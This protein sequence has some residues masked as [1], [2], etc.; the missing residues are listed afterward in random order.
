MEWEELLAQVDEALL[1]E[2]EEAVEDIVRQAEQYHQRPP[3]DGPNGMKFYDRHGFFE[4]LEALQDGWALL[5]PRIPHA[6]ILAWRN[7]HANHPARASPVPHRRCEDCLMVL[8]N[9]TP[10]GFG[11]CISPCPVCGSE[12]LAWADL[13]KPPGNFSPWKKPRWN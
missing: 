2:S 5:P 4:W 10:D 12:R 7:G 9:C 8:P 3:R 13:S 1:P 6:V 11:P